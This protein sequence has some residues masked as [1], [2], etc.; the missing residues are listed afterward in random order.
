[1]NAADLIK[2]EALRLGLDACGIAKAEAV[3][4]EEAGH[5]QTWITEGFHGGMSYLE[6]NKELRNDPR[7]LVE[8]ARSIIVV[9]LNYYPHKH[10]HPTAPQIARYAYGM[11]YHFVLKEKLTNLLLFINRNIAPAQGRCFVDSAPVMES[12]WAWKA[13]I[14]WRG[15]NHL[16]IL[17]HRGSYFFLGELILD[18]ALPPDTPM[19]SHCGTCTSCQDA[20]PTCAFVSPQILNAQRCISY[21]T[22]ENHKEI[23][24]EVSDL[25][26]N[27][28][29]GCDR[30]QEVCPYNRFATPHTCKNLLPT[31]EFIS[32][33]HD[34]WINLDKVTFNRLF[35]KSAIQRGGYVKLR[36]QLNRI[37]GK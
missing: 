32:M 22:I 27:R 25:F 24:K 17:P 5:F 13:G 30:C 26:G 34:D 3:D 37:S 15:K 36:E 14:G 11:D 23:P 19:N 28:I 6:R 2:Q 10:Q 7:L 29:Y 20:C 21:Q 18:L 4:E 1:M 9:A 31:N 33:D 8:N 16:I 12:Y 35:K